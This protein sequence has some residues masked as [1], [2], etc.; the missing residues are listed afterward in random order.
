MIASGTGSAASPAWPRIGTG[1][2]GPVIPD[3]CHTS[4][5]SRGTPETSTRPSRVVRPVPGN[6]GA[7]I[8]SGV[9]PLD[10][11]S[12]ARKLLASSAATWPRK[13]ESIFL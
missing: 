1:S 3:F 12:A 6:A 10:W 7:K 9:S 4:L 2:A 11:A 13:V 5:C 8:T